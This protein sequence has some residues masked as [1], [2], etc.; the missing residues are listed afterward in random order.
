M[1]MRDELFEREMKT[2]NSVLLA[3]GVHTH[4]S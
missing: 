1:N 3:T 4:F 2:E